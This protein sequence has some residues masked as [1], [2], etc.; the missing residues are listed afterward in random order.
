MVIEPQVLLMDEP[1]SNLDAKLRIEMREEIRDMQKSLGVTT[2]YVTHDQEE[3]LVISDRIAIMNKGEIQQI[4]KPWEIYNE[5]ENEFVAS[6][7][8]HMN[9]LV[10]E[11]QKAEKGDGS[12]V[13][14]GKTVIKTN[15]NANLESKVK[16]AMR[17]EDITYASKDEIKKEDHFNYLTGRVTKISFTGSGARFF[18]ECNDGIQI[19]MDNLKPNKENLDILN[20]QVN[21]KF[22]IDSVM[23]FD[24]SNGKTLFK[25]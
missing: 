21:V 22:S 10:G 7:I 12:I 5:P 24:S 4:A 15:Y 9:V 8:G 25:G 14:V 23:V 16:L 11:C 19:I 13:M 6:F 1:L 20:N 17:P 3:A 18:I 2:I